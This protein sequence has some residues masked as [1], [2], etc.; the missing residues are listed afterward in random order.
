MSLRRLGFG[1]AVLALGIVLLIVAPAAALV[2]EVFGTK[3]GK[4]YH[5]QPNE[6][7]SARKIQGDN[8]VTFQAEQDAKNAGRRICKRCETLDRQPAGKSDSPKKSGGVKGGGDDSAAGGAGREDHDAPPTSGPP[9]RI[10]GSELT[11]E[12]AR[13]TSV[14]PGGTLVLDNGEHATLVG[15]VCPDRGQPG[16]KDSVRFLIEQTRGRTIRL[17]I[18]GG[19]CRPDARD[20]HGRLCIYATPEPDGRDLGGELIF[21]GY[22]WVDR[23]AP[24]ERQDEYLRFEEDAWRGGRGVWVRGEGLDAGGESVVTGRHAHCYHPANCGHSKILANVMPLTLSE[25]R[26]RR[27]VPCSEFRSR[28]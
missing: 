16:E 6:C 21:Q 12:V 3:R 23:A 25:A 13:V 18:E 17:T 5:T 19:A 15:V 28:K 11:A 27:L 2:R 14:L 24:F 8:R 7:A 22:A 9:V 10:A 4:V 20:E 1:R 26:A